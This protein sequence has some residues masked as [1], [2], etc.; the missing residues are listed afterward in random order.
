MMKKNKEYT[1]IATVE[2]TVTSDTEL[3]IEDILAPLNVDKIEV[4]NYKVFEMEVE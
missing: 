1:T 4:K 2:I 3:K